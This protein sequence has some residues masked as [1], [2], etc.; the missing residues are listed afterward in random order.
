MYTRAIAIAAGVLFLCLVVLGAWYV[1]KPPHHR[2]DTI[3]GSVFT[4]AKGNFSIEIAPQW[5]PA[6]STVA[7][8]PGFSGSQFVFV[9]GTC[10]LAYAVGEGSMHASGNTYKQTT[11]GGARGITTV[12]NTQ[13]DSWWWVPTKNLPKGYETKF[14]GR[15]PYPGEV[16]VATSMYATPGDMPSAFLLYTTDG[17]PVP[18]DC[19]SDAEAMFKTLQ[20]S[21]SPASLT[22]TSSGTIKE[23]I[24]RIVQNGSILA[25][26]ADGSEG[27]GALRAY[28][29]YYQNFAVYNDVLYSITNGSLLTLNVFSGVETPLPGIATSSDALVSDFYIKGDRLWYLLGTEGCNTYMATCSLALYEIPA[30]G[31]VPTKLATTTLQTGSIMGYDTAGNI[32]YLESGTGDAGCYRSQI[33]AFNYAD[34]TVASVVEDAG[35]SDDPP[36]MHAEANA[37]TAAIRAAIGPAPKRSN[38]LQVRSGHLVAPADATTTLGTSFLFPAR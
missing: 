18:D 8:P 3:G 11:P 38:S 22:T 29:V 17:A 13:L 37:K 14:E 20:P 28:N 31:G 21:F 15:E 27:Y 2:V 16:R 10:A 33:S 7:L 34:G 9:H 25:F 5:G 1:Y 32:L 4:Y 23:F 35:C 36:S 24:E 30:K 6:T 26:K 12:G 19:D